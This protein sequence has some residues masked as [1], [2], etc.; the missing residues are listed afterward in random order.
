MMTA[1]IACLVLTTP[2]SMSL[3]PMDL[4][5]HLQKCNSRPKPQP[6]YWI[7]D[8][9]VSDVKAAKIEMI[10]DS[11]AP[12]L[13]RDAL[14]SLPAEKF[15]TLVSKIR[16]L[17]AKT[18]PDGKNDYESMILSH[19]SMKERLESSND[20]KH[21]AQQ[22]SLLGHL[23]R[24]GLLSNKN[25]FLEF[26]AGKG[27]LAHWI[28]GAVGDASR[29]VL[30]DRQNFRQ[31]YD[32]NISNNPSNSVER[33][34]MDIKDLDLT[35][36]EPLKGYPSVAASKH[37]CGA[38]TDITL[39][40]IGNYMQGGGDV[41]GLV[42]AL[43][44]HQVCKFNMYSN[45]SFLDAESIDENEFA[46]ICVMSTWAVCGSKTPRAKAASAD[47]I[48]DPETTPSVE[49]DAEV[50]DEQHSLDLNA[51]D[52]AKDEDHWSGLS[53]TDRET[54]GFQC[55]RILDYGRLDYVRNM[56]FEADLLYYVGRDKS[57]E[58]LALVAR[59]G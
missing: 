46:F 20:G 24:L 11:T 28:H 3:K 18:L 15:A 37:L 17:Y 4:V 31:K 53:F 22:A 43:C 52:M 54:L 34:A 16:S 55:K 25:V 36:Y 58:N 30:I 2:Y 41:R 45:R 14:K 9:N 44:C 51:E 59:R 13:P 57:L 40:C 21:P 23:D 33:I 26:G 32:K 47:S 10:A 27:E 56:G 29:F 50:E 7:E 12:I 6:A 49:D 38:A 42:I 19:S 39:R 35:K 1:R 48:T 8:I 5:R